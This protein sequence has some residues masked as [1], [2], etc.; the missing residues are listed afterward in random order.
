M[1]SKQ[2][3]C[4]SC[5]SLDLR[6]EDVATMRAQC[7]RCR[8]RCVIE[9]DGSTRDWLRLGVNRTALQPIPERSA[10]PEQSCLNTEPP[11]LDPEFDSTP[12]PEWNFAE[13]LA[14]PNKMQSFVRGLAAE[15]DRLDLEYGAPTEAP[16]R[17]TELVASDS[18]VDAIV[19]QALANDLPRPSGS[20]LA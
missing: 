16:S 6:I 10:E 17:L 14:S 5:Q 8:W 3:T 11:C 12:L 19:E 13:L 1:T 7:Q 18:T 2:P 15:F 20:T 4:P 9:S